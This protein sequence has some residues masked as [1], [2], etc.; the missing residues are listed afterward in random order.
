MGTVRPAPAFD[1][2]QLDHVLHRARVGLGRGGDRGGQK[3]KR[4]K[5]GMG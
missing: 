2:F 1:Q 5:R 4:A 3:A